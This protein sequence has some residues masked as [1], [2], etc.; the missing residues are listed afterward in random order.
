MGSFQVRELAEP[1]PS[2]LIESLRAF[3]YSLPTAVADLVDNSLTASASKVET[4]FDWRGGSSSICVVDNGVGMSR[5]RLVEAMRPGSSSPLFER[6]PKDLG[7]FGLGLKTASFSQCRRVTVHSKTA[8]GIETERTWDLDHVG[9]TS[10]WELVEVDDPE[11]KRL[12]EPLHKHVS[13]TAVI[14]QVCDRVVPTTADAN[15]DKAQRRFLEL[16]DEVMHHLS[17]VFHRFIDGVPPV[18]FSINGNKIKAFDPFLSKA[19]ATQILT[20]ET[21]RLH[22]EPVTVRPFVLPH[23]SKLS[24]AEYEGAAGR[25][26]WAQ[27]QGFYVYRNRRLLVDG[28]WLSL[29]LRKEDHY[30]LARIQVDIPNTLDADWQIDVRKARAMPPPA[31]RDRLHQIASIT[32][33]QASNIY[34]HRGARLG[35]A[36]N[37]LTLLWERK[38]SHGKPR[39]ALNRQHPAIKRLETPA[40]CS[41]ANVEAVLRL[42]EESIP[43]PTISIDVAE[44][45]DQQREPFEHTDVSVL[46]QLGRELAESMR[47]TGTTPQDAAAR[48]AAFEPYNKLP[49]IV[50]MILEESTNG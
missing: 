22:G 33:A 20:E 44:Y 16:A 38:I 26:G 41:P 27:S 40:D 37:E 2:S 17:L 1:N 39:Y 21:L 23:H 24:S 9:A 11:I 10:T 8:D 42:I 14:W 25:R 48:L 31:L 12:C 49:H 30:K 50:Q 7:R 3:G 18:H 19:T 13:G 32:R 47:A 6:D 5:E 45:A 29:G 35:N 4:Y 15:D 28:D 36:Q 43:V 34:R 46:V